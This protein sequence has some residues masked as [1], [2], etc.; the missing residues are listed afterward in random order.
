MENDE[1]DQTPQAGRGLFVFAVTSIDELV[2]ECLA[3]GQPLLCARLFFR[4]EIPLRALRRHF[5]FSFPVGKF[6][7]PLT[8]GQTT[9]IGFLLL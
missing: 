1:R 9:R 4:T 3:L 5:H 2:V 7:P 8:R 6:Q